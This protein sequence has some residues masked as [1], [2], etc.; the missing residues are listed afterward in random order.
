MAAA[1]GPF[2]RQRL[3]VLDDPH[4]AGHHFQ[5][6]AN[7]DGV[8]LTVGDTVNGVG[9]GSQRLARRRTLAGRRGAVQHRGGPLAPA[10]CAWPNTRSR[11]RCRCA[12]R[13]LAQRVTSIAWLVVVNLLLLG[14]RHVPRERPGALAAHPRPRRDERRGPAVRLVRRVDA[15][16][17]ALHAPG[18]LRVARAR[19]ADG[20][21]RV[22]AARRCD[23]P[24]SRSRSTGRG[25]PAI[26]TCW[27]R[28]SPRP[29]CTS[30]CR[31]SSRTGR[32][33]RARSRPR[34]SW[35]GWAS[36]CGA[37]GSGRRAPAA[38]CTRRRCSRRRSASRRPVD[39]DQPS[40]K[41]W[42][43]SRRAST[44]R[45]RSRPTR[46]TRAAAKRRQ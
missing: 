20:G 40:S 46:K 18:P 44:P 9:I 26:R 23:D 13:V 37:T 2:A 34:P 14:V 3:L 25:S 32:S 36:R 6:D 28:R 42:S 33:S 19:A 30:T 10:A 29:R 17:E 35:W 11:P 12:T 7:D 22:A 1:R 21:H 5:V 8:Y 4:V 38:S 43:R 45:P 24:R 31:P 15:A 27:R 41:A 16:V 39:T